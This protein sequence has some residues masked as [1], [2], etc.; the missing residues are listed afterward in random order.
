MSTK[1]TS[2]DDYGGLMPMERFEPSTLAGPVF[3]TGA[4][5]VPPHRLV[6]DYGFIIPHPFSKVNRFIVQFQRD[7]I[8]NHHPALISKISA[9]LLPCCVM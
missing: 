2:I 1:K 6:I 4:Y 9:S 3:E 7:K 5:T 8:K